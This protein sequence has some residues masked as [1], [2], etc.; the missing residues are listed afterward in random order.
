MRTILILSA[1]SLAACGATNV[2]QQNYD[3]VKAANAPEGH[4]EGHGDGHGE[5][6]AHG[7]AAKGDAG[8]DHAAADA[9]HEGGDGAADAHGEGEGDAA[10]EGGEA[11][12][13]GGERD[14]A[15]GQEVYKT[16]CISCH[17]ADG[18]GMNGLAANLAEDKSRLAK[19]M[20]TL[21]KHIREG[22]T[23]EIGAM[24]PWGAVVSDSDA[25]DVVAW[26]RS[27]Y[28]PE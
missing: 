25:R 22:Y 23:G 15:K 6:E 28:P 2:N 4:G 5:G 14:L 27:E 8:G 24:P 20:D 19:D 3:T 16:Y 18:K 9:G 7:D 13:A 10:A 12:A 26:L 1:L 11:A 21:V 17:G